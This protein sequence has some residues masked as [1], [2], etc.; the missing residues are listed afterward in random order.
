MHFYSEKNFK[1][2]CIG[3]LVCMCIYQQ[4][5]KLLDET[6]I[7]FELKSYPLNIFVPPIKFFFLKIESICFNSQLTL[8][9]P[10][11]LFVRYD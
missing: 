8:N 6:S 11:E 1:I 9:E 3:S 10:I 2:I 7:I 4:L 5:Y